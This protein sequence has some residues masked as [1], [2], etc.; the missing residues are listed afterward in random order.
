MYSSE[1]KYKKE[2]LKM[3]K[4]KSLFITICTFAVFLLWTVGVKFID[5]Q[6]VGPQGS[7]VGFATINS[8]YHD[9]TGVHMSLYT[10]TDHLSIIPIGF[11]LSFGIL[12][13]IQLIKRKSLLRVDRFLLLFGIFY[14][15]VAITYI[16]FEIVVINYRPILIDGRLEPSYPSSTTMLVLCVMITSL[17][18]LKPRIKRTT[19]KKLTV[20]SITVFTVFMVVCRFLSGVHWFSDIIGGGLL[21]ASLVSLYCFLR[22]IELFKENKTL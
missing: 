16:F 9:L 18:E 2:G 11:V 7:A 17:I 21:S 13:L 8:F 3:K 12:A 19:L 20:T 15:T 22:K 1:S 5:V 10:I 14:I 6:A 4:E